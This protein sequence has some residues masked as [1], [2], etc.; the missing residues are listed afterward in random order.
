MLLMISFYPLIFLLVWAK[1]L[2]IGVLIVVLGLPYLIKSLRVYNS[3][4][5]ETPGP[6]Y[7]VGWSFYHNRVVGG[8]FFLGLIVN[9]V[10]E[11]V[12]RG[13]TILQI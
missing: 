11:S 4:R 9:V 7:Y 13:I 2:G 10:L 3:P 1:I 6:L 12:S 8:L 5:P